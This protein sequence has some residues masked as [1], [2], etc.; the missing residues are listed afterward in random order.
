MA[1][2]FGHVV[3]STALGYAFF[4]KQVKPA[5]LLLAGLCAFAPD[6]DVLAFH[7]GIP[8]QSQWGH[9]G[10]THSAVFTLILGCLLGYFVFRQRA[11]RNRIAL[12]FALSALSHPLLDMMTTGGLGCAFWWPFDD[13][14]LFLPFRPIRVSPLG[15]GA[16]FSQWGLKVLE[17]EAVWIGLPAIA[18][19]V[20]RK[21]VGATAHGQ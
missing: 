12:W 9:R 6:S 21:L 8:Y 18:L 19:I 20:L 2:I 10:W 7:F 1:S 3:A 15:A 14:R 16:F 11:D 5:T 13:T 4:P 17:S